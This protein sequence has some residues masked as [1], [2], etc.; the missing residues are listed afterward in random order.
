LNPT[1]LLQK[2]IAIEMSIGVES[3]TAIR[4]SLQEAEDCLLQMQRES[5]ESFWV[6]TRQDSAKRFDFLRRITPNRQT[7]V[8]R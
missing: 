5:V 2:L 7:D 4:N 8:A 6:E 3:N 1:I